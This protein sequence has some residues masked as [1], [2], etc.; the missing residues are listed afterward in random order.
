MRGGEEDLLLDTEKDT[1]DVEVHYA[2]PAFVG[3]FF[4]WCAPYIEDG[5]DQYTDE[6]YR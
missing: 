1:F 3:V 4:E 5:R 2:I 6:M